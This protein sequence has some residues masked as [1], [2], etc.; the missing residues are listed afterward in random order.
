[1]CVFFNICECEYDFISAC[2]CVVLFVLVKKFSCAE[3]VFSTEYGLMS[4]F[5]IVTNM[6]ILFVYVYFFTICVNV[7]VYT[8]KNFYIQVAFK[9]SR[10]LHFLKKSSFDHQMVACVLYCHP[11]GYLSYLGNS[12]EIFKAI[13][14]LQQIH[15]CNLPQEKQ[16]LLSAAYISKTYS[17]KYFQL[18]TIITFIQQESLLS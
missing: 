4:D 11:T 6:H 17:E 3:S 10:Y 14:N 12:H 7:C 13:S 16:V 15:R 1:M 18:A 9:Q 5:F 2:M 8:T